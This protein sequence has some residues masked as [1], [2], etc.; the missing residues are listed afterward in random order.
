MEK[1]ITLQDHMTNSTITNR[2]VEHCEE[3][4]LSQK[5]KKIKILYERE[6]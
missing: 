4:I 5:V 6:R 3:I 2:I 1:V